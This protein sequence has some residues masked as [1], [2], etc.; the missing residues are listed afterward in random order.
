M[1]LA[2]NAVFGSWNTPRAVKYRCVRLLA[3][4]GWVEAQE[5]AAWGL[6]AAPIRHAAQCPRS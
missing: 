2:I 4:A 5:W 1:K 6:A 3:A